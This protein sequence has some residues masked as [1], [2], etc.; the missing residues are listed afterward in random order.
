M[1]Y[2]QHVSLAFSLLLTLSACGG[3]RSSSPESNETTENAAVQEEGGKQSVPTL[4]L[5]IMQKLVDSV[6]Y[7]DYIWY[8][9]DF[10]MS[11]D[12]P[13]GVRY[14]LAQIGESGANRTAACKPAGRVFYQ[15]NGRNAA[16]A[17]MFFSNGC[18]YMEF[19]EDGK[20]VYANAMSPVGIDFLNNQFGALIKDYQ[21]VE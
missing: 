11:M 14:S 18:T 3:E 9:F 12:N 10:S 4:P 13:S 7:V 21:R 6:D 17:E 1:S 5:T 16:E 2:L 19:I 8:N 20:V 15:I